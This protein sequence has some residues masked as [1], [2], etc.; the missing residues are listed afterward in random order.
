MQQQV[1]RFERAHFDGEPAAEP[2][3]Q[4]GENSPP[5]EEDEIEFDGADET[6]AAVTLAERGR[7]G[8]SGENEGNQCPPRKVD[9]DAAPVGRV[10]LGRR[11]IRQ[12]H[13]LRK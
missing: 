9:E 4:E 1:A 3:N 12:V 5:I 6:K 8:D 7:V 11:V 13:G 2:E 10:S